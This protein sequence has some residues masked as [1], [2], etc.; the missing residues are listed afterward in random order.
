LRKVIVGLPQHP[1]GRVIRLIVLMNAAA[2]VCAAYFTPFMLTE[3]KLS[4]AQFTVLNATILVARLLSSAYWGEI[5]RNFGNAGYMYIFLGSTVLRLLIA[6]LFARGAGVRRPV[7]HTFRTVFMRVV[8]LRPG[9]G[10]GLRPIVMA[11]DDTPVSN[12]SDQQGQGI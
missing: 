3:L 6:L 2:Y 10:Q 1:Y 8:S 11:N 4:Y 9:Q 5:V 7:E 12:P